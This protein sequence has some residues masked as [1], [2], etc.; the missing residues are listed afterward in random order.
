MMA[1]RAFRWAA[2]LAGLFAAALFVTAAAGFSRDEAWFLQVVDRVLRGETLY[3]DVFFLSTPLAVQLT[4]AAAH[5]FGSGILVEKAVTTAAF[6]GE[7][8]FGYLLAR[9]CGASRMGGWLVWPALFVYAWHF[10]NPPYRALGS[11]LML[12]SF[13]ALLSWNRRAREDDA[14][15]T[16]ALA[17]SGAFAGTCLAAMPNMGMLAALSAVV[18][19]IANGWRGGRSLAQTLGRL[20]W[21]AAACALPVLI[22][23]APVVL[24]GSLGR[25]VE[26]TFLNKAPYVESGGAS[27]A[28][29][30]SS[31]LLINPIAAPGALAALYRGFVVLLAPA[32]LGGAILAWVRVKDERRGA[33]LI[34]LLLVLSS[35]LAAYPRM[36]RFHLS[37]GAPG[38]IAG[39][40]YAWRVLVPA[41]AIRPAVVHAV[42]AVWLAAGIASSAVDVLRV[43]RSSDTVWSSLPHFHGV[44][45]ARTDEAAILGN[46]DRLRGALGPSPLMVMNDAGMYYLVAGLRN[47]TPFDEPHLMNFGTHGQAD[48]IAALAAGS[49]G[50]VCFRAVGGALNPA[51][52]EQYVESHMT[53][54]EDFGVCVA[55][56]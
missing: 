47:P 54:G 35:A 27:Y 22:A 10:P 23:I 7:C 4:V 11:A 46:A 37:Y 48:V 12:G 32:S 39:L 55:Y 2:G 44:R 31:L 21:F 29:E 56:R 20:A 38:F 26:F 17:A 45:I 50:P 9:A 18:V 8:A 14:R 33:A 41:R 15:A 49:I 5:V 16:A 24:T 36:N 25:F 43:V 40:V 19:V 51:A 1:S 30:L 34:V 6:T 42:L 13:W 3:R 28:A 52:I 53:R